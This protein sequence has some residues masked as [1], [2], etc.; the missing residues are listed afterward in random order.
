M[1][2]E[3]SLD[4]IPYLLLKEYSFTFEKKRL[5]FLQIIQYPTVEGP[6]HT[7]IITNHNYR[8]LLRDGC[9]RKYII[10]PPRGKTND[11]VSEQVRNKPAWTVIEKS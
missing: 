4:F 1:K 8:Q 10:E 5:A 6:N 2:N 7:Q 3:L 11:V 9:R